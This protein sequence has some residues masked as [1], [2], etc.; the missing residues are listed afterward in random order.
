MIN[1]QCTSGYDKLEDFVLVEP[2]NI[3]PKINI[4]VTLE[5]EEDKKCSVC[6]YDLAFTPSLY[7]MNDYVSYCPMCS[8]MSS[9]AIGCE[10]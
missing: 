10:F 8:L 3:V 1:E 9:I 6:G 2:K 5:L 4:T 7:Q